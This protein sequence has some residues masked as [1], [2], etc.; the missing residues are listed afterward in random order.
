MLL[1][2]LKQDFYLRCVKN[3]YIAYNFKMVPAMFKTPFLAYNGVVASE[4]PLASVTGVKVLMNGGNAFDA[5][6]ATSFTLA[7]TQPHLGGLGGDFFALFYSA[8]Q[9]KIY[10]LNSSGWAPRKLTIEFLKNLGYRK[11]PT[12]SRF[13]VT[14]PGLVAG[15]NELHRKFGSLEF[16]ELL[17]DPI[18]FAENGFP[19]YWSLSRAIEFGAKNFADEGFRENYLINGRP[20]KVGEILK[21]ENLAEVLKSIAR[22]GPGVFYKG[23]IAEEIVSYLN[24]EEEVFSVS[25]FSDFKPEWCKPISTTYHNIRVYEIPPNS[26]G[27]TTLLMLN[28]L[29]ELNLKNIDPFSEKRIR[30]VTEVAKLAYRER[31]NQLSDPRFINIDLA[32]FISKSFAQELLKEIPQSVINMKL[33]NGDTTYFAVADK[34]G[35]IVSAI[36]SLFHPFGSRIVVKSLGIPLNNRGSYFKF[37][38]PNKL[39]PRKR[40]LHTL[41]AL[42][43]EDDE[44]VFAAL[45]ASGGDFRPQQHALFVSN[46][47]D[48]EMSIWEALEAPRFLWDGEKILVEEGYK[49]SNNEIYVKLKYPGRTGVA[50]GIYKKDE[51]LIGV[52]DVR[53]DGLPC[54]Y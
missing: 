21:Q 34:E 37:E 53:G 45:G 44:G 4:H 15:L 5:T 49:I 30:L 7:V 33:S 11:M 10:C 26:M 32:K 23:W 3:F 14:V 29:E 20:P 18:S 39:E 41:S 52:S 31:D 24:R 36:Q 25:D 6:I 1:R 51:T 12:F 13:S 42:L 19:V 2:I 50:Q 48:Y 27:A 46:I 35:N 9:G 8:D 17:K 40:S 16:D 28:M 38:G 43:L 47:V 22:E 54:G